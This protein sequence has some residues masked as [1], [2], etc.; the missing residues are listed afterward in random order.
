MGHNPAT[1]GMTEGCSA[2]TDTS[3]RPTWQVPITAIVTIVVILAIAGTLT[4]QALSVNA[5]GTSAKPGA[6]ALPN[7]VAQALDSSPTPSPLA[8]EP[9]IDNVV[10]VLADDLDWETFNQVPRLK[11][12]QERGMTLSSTVVT[13]SLCC[14]S[15]V[16]I[17]RSQYVHNHRV[18]SN[19]VESGGGWPTFY[20]LGEQQDCLPLWLQKAGVRTGFF[21][22]YLNDYPDGAPSPTYIPPGWNSWAVPVT[23]AAAYRGYGY[24][25]NQDGTL[26]KYGDKPKDFLADVLTKGATDF[27]R[28]STSP[29]FVELSLMNPHMPAPVAPRHLRSNA[30]V[31]VPRNPT[32]NARGLNEPD[33]RSRKLTMSQA[34][35]DRYDAIWRK[36]V[37]SSE[38]VADAVDAVLKTLADTGKLERTLVIVGSDNGFHAVS[39]RLPPGK[40]TPYREDTVVPFLLI[41]PGATAG[42]TV[43]SM[44]STI[45]LGPTIGELLGAQ[46]PDWVDG[47]SLVPFLR[48]SNG[49]DWRT[50]ILTESL[51][52][53]NPGDP[54]YE[55]FKP[56]KFEALRTERYLYVEYADGTRELFDHATDPYEMNNVIGSADP[57]LLADLAAQLKALVAC[58][59]PSCRV[60]DAMP[61]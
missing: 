53:S 19:V 18:I 51:G 36:R 7:A 4:W 40:R 44:T 59:G 20:S 2:V 6:G 15:R 21:G 57:Q 1:T 56:P 47:R 5:A 55:A 17:F 54:D 43:T 9:E 52:E 39:R 48:G 16:S 33:W 46:V 35:L 22:K 37:R 3:S 25:L 34:R 58:A 38:S 10:F 31:T 60:A 26:V 13:D 27:I 30:N 61:H 23:Q 24:T 42:S 41:G 49:A 45:D 50:G 14:P 32:Y 12:L 8:P 11:A 28:T 29:F